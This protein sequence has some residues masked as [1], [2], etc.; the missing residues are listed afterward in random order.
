MNKPLEP[1]FI[2]LVA[3]PSTGLVDAVL[4][5]AAGGQAA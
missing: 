2:R 4:S 5:E 3:D 1:W